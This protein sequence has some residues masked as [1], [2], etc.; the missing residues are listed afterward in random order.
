MGREKGTQRC[1]K[2][3]KVDNIEFKKETDKM[4]IK[5][6]INEDLEH[7]QLTRKKFAGN[8]NNENWCMIVIAIN[9]NDNNDNNNN[10]NKNNNNNNNN[11]KKKDYS[12]E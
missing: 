7:K 3:E 12:N 10:N 2:N 5:F 8:Y 6:E 4:E 9:N 11:N 1:L